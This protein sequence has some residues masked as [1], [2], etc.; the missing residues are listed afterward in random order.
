MPEE[1]EYG[2]YIIYVRPRFIE[3]EDGTEVPGF[4]ADV[5]VR[6]TGQDSA[7]GHAIWDFPF[8]HAESHF[9][10]VIRDGAI[11]KARAYI[12]SAPKRS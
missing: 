6:D 2:G 7:D 11:A 1:V 5:R 3:I 12:D 8:E 4:A 10:D 9:E